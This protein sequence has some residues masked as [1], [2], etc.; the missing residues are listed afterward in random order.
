M[1]DAVLTV[2]MSCYNQA[3]TLRQAVDS[4][5]MQETDFPFRLLITDDCS[6]KDDSRRLICE[7]V[8]RCPDRIE[9]LLNDEN[10]RYLA[11]ILRA[12]A[13]T[14]T[15]FITLLDADDYWTDPHYLQDALNFL[16]GHDDYAVYFRNVRCLQE[17]GTESLFLPAEPWKTEFCFDDYVNGFVL[18]PQTAGAVFRNVVYRDGIPRIIADA[19][20][21]LHERSYEGD[22]DRYLMHLAKGKSHYDPRPSGVYRILASGI[23]SRLSRSSQ[24]LIQAQGFLDNFAYFKRDRAFFANGA[25]RELRLALASV[26]TEINDGRYPDG[27]W[28]EYFASVCAACAENA[29]LILRPVEV[30]T[31]EESRP[32]FRI[33]LSGLR[34]CLVRALPEPVRDLYKGLRKRGK[35]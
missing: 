1:T 28:Q 27:R 22:V 10:G 24:H 7:L 26:Q 33:V 18:I 34:S 14:K 6:T 11:N 25:Y 13:R 8:A 9:A 19:V 31:R 17:D 21:T 12:K 35:G 29:D 4:V 23:W 16:R 2:I 3:D 32:V 20:G 5:L 30:E 15:E